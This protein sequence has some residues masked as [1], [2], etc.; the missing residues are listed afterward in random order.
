MGRGGRYP[1]TVDAQKIWTV[2]TTHPLAAR[3][4]FDGP[5]RTNP[6]QPAC[7]MERKLACSR[8]TLTSPGT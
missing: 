2:F 5:M 6:I 4:M 7:V 1:E 3:F 8:E